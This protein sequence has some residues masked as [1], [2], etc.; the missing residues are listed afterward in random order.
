MKKIY[1]S[2]LAVSIG[3]LSFGQVAVKKA[4]PLRTESIGNVV[5]QNPVEKPKGAL[6]WSNDFS[7]S[8]DW[9][10]SNTSSPATDWIITNDVNASPAGAGLNPAGMAT[11]ANGY[12]LIDSDGPGSSASQNAIIH[13]TTP[14][15]TIGI[16][17]VSL[18]FQQTHRRFQEQTIVIVSTNG[19]TT[20]TEFEVNTA[21]SPNTNSPNPE[22]I[23]VNISSA[24]ANQAAVLVGFKYV[25]AWDWFWAV[26]DVEVRESDDND[27]IGFN[28]FYGSQQGE[29]PYTRIPVAQNQPII[30]S[31]EVTNIGAATQTATKVTASINSGAVYAGVSPTVNLAPLASDSLSPPAFTPAT[32]VG[33]AHNLELIVSSD[34]TDVSPANNINAFPPFEISQY[35]YALDDFGTTP[36][37]G[38]GPRPAPSNSVEYEAGNFFDIVANDNV[39]SIDVVVGT[40]PA[41]TGKNIDVVLYDASGAN[42]V[43]LG[44]SAFYTVAAS[45]LGQKVTLTLVDANTGLPLPVAVT[46]G[47]FYFAA[48]HCFDEFYY[49]ISGD[50]PD[51][52]SRGGVASLIFYPNMVSPNTNEN[53]FT[54]QTPMVRL[55]FEAPNS[56]KELSN[57]TSF[58]VYPNPSNGDFNISLNTQNAEMLTLTVNNIV[59][60]TVLTKQVRVAGQTNETISLAG[61]DKGVYFLTIDNNKEKQTVKLIVE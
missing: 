24:A 40:N 44:R 18:T 49:G 12:A 61:F 25:A 55:N 16:S 1:L 32:T 35:I 23:T 4:H 38:G 56:V 20:W 2:L 13:I 45:D 10:M 31:Q 33:V 11:A 22:T 27:L 39:H 53:F 57:N 42:F 6:I 36:G 26:D 7:S 51:N 52:T 30:F 37:N 47:N 34:S 46:A 58:S 8:S 59:G 21:M 14:F 3:S 15:S 50:S 9:T 17:A 54:T 29:L 19:G 60:Q 48:V 41:N 28:G 43:E 5:K